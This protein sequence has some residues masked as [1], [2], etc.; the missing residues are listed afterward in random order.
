MDYLSSEEYD[1]MFDDEYEQWLLNQNKKKLKMRE[2]VYFVARYLANGF[3]VD[4]IL[5]D[6]RVN[7]FE[8][9][10]N[11]NDYDF[12]SAMAFYED[13]EDEIH[14]KRRAFLVSCDY[15]PSESLDEM[16]QDEIAE[17]YTD[18]FFN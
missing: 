18:L 4:N 14:G 15:N 3:S 6:F 10:E 12:T 16:W 2:T 9:I 1:L 5:S 7:Y 17:F 8:A 13:M 11:A